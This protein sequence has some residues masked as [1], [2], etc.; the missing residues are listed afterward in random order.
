MR[1]LCG[2]LLP[3]AMSTT[4]TRAAGDVNSPL[5]E[6][7]SS[8][9]RVKKSFGV[10]T[11]RVEGYSGLSTRVGDSTESPEFELCGHTWQ[12]RIFPGGSLDAHR[13]HLSYYLASKSTRSARASYKLAVCSQVLGGVDEV[14]ASSGVRVFEAKG[15][16]IDGWGRDKFMPAAMLLEPDF[17][18]VVDDVAVFKVEITVFG[19]LESASYPPVNVVA[20]NQ[21]LPTLAR[22]LQV[23]A[24]LP[25]PPMDPRWPTWT[26]DASPHTL[27]CTASHA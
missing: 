2:H 8:V 20:T 3:T 10:Y 19:D 4:L 5:V 21:A 9:S 13:T 22:C 15:V 16:Q 26:D 12:L 23:H 11:F 1:C 24:P 25:P 6:E 7:K 27:R 14:F 18:F 17:G